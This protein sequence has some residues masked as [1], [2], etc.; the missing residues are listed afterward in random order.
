VRLIHR[1][2]L[3]DYAL[4]LICVSV[5]L[6]LTMMIMPL[7][8]IVSFSFFFAAVAVSAWYG[9]FGPGVFATALATLAGDYFLMPPT[10]T[11]G[12]LAPNDAV[13]IVLFAFGSI[14]IAVLMEVRKRSAEAIRQEREWLRVVLASISD[15]VIATDT[16]GH[17]TFMN[18]VAQDLTG[19]S[20]REVEGKPLTGFFKIID[21]KTRDP[22][23]NPVT[24][25]I[26]SGK[27][28]ITSSATLLVSKSGSEIPI[29]N[30]SAPIRN[31][32]DR[33]IGV[34]LIFREDIERHMTESSTPA[35]TL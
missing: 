5:A 7:V 20:Q 22:L 12:S 10:H 21:E 35:S 4:A 33:L 31:D 23:S 17:V 13:R 19:W 18:H 32:R 11:F 1:P 26:V 16:N 30:S 24:Q 28:V 6:L 29:T 14:L 2:I 34:V 9:G 25:V 3:L 8:Q 15:G 27:V